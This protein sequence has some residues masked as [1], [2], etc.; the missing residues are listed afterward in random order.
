MRRITPVGYSQ[1]DPAAQDQVF[2]IG[3]VAGGTSALL[4]ASACLNVGSLLLS[5]AVARRPEL[6]VKVAL[7]AT[8][9]M[10]VRQLLTEGIAVSLAGGA[11]GL[12]FAVWTARALPALFMIEQAELLDTRLD[13]RTMLLTLGVACLA[14]AIFGV[15]PAL[16]GTAFPPAIALRGDA[17]GVSTSQGGTQLRALLLVG[18]V[19]LS[20]ILLLATALLITGLSRALEGALGPTARRVAVLSMELPGRFGDPARGVAARNRLLEQLPS[21]AGVEAVAWANTL[22]L[23]RGNKRPFRIQAETTDVTDTVELE[24]NVVSPDYFRVLSL[25]LLEGRLFDEGDHTRA[26]PVIVVDELFAHRYLGQKALGRVIADAAGVQLKVVGVVRGGRY[27]TLQQS[28]Q[29][30]IYY[31][32]T[33]DYLWRGHLLVRTTGDPA[34]LLAPLSAIVRENGGGS[35]VLRASTLEAHLADSLA[36]DRI[37]TAL[38]GVCGIVAL[39]MSTIGVYGVMADAVVRRT[40]EIGLRVALGAGRFQVVRLVS[41][42]GLA[43]AACGLVAGIAVA[44]LARFVARWF[45]EGVPSLDVVTL[46]AVAGALTTVTAVAAV[47]PL[48]RALRVHPNIALRAE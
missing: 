36:I 28:P 4:L 30:T 40:R 34:T 20:T 43:L 2:L 17:G 31:P 22:P 18:Q 10:L 38:V 1:L 24:T 44:F 12:L 47:L 7:G 26:D 42:E 29:P 39:L 32:S 5:R 48:R 45:V 16:H 33:Q 19:A 35:S 6:A 15:S 11:L 8:R 37:A 25:P 23:G 21:S 27:R 41:M 46:A 3:L 9:R 13:P 14:G